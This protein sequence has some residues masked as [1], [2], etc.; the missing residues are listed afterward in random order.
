MSDLPSSC[1][2]ISFCPSTAFFFF[3]SRC[4]QILSYIYLILLL[5]FAARTLSLSCLFFHSFIFETVM[6]ALPASCTNISFCPSTVSSLFKI[7]P[8]KVPFSTETYWHFSYFTKKICCGYSLEASQ[9]F[10]YVEV[11]R[12]SQPIRVML[13]ALPNTFSGQA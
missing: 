7:D 5:T 10:V 6:S 9:Q 2:N 13:S 1:T 4:I 8:D 11:L 3:F 12:P